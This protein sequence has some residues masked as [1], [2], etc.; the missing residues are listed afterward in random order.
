[1][2]VAVY[3][4]G[5]NVYYR[6]LKHTHYKWLDPLI[7]AQ[8]LLDAQD[9]IVMVRYFTARISSRAGDPDAPRRQEIYLKAL[10]TIPQMRIH[11]GRFLAKT[12]I[13]PLVGFDDCFVE[14]QD[15]E[16]KGSDVN[17]ASYLIHD[18]WLGLYDAALVM[19]QDSDLCEPMRMVKEELEKPL[20]IVWLDGQQPSK[21]FRRSSSFV[22][23]VT[24]SRLDAAQFPD[25]IMG[26][27][28]HLIRKPDRW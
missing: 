12:K 22:R 10:R 17:L 27:D 14:I 20:G 19:S 3:V 15:T 23:H 4:D 28:G 24:S 1:M 26:R 16:E 18:G 21:H 7:L 8:S 6:A 5:F 9:E 13:R 2:R 11:Y 25:T